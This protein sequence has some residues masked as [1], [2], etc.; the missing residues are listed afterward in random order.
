MRILREGILATRA[1]NVNYKYD[2]LWGFELAKLEFCVVSDYIKLFMPDSRAPVFVQSPTTSPKWPVTP[3]VLSRN[4]IG[5]FS[6][7]GMCRPGGPLPNI[8]EA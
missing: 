7:T 2:F 5:W 3:A 1:A 6:I 4:P 8:S